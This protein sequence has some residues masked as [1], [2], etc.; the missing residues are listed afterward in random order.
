LV[1]EY[2]CFFGAWILVLG[3]SGALVATPDA[4]RNHA[5]LFARQFHFQFVKRAG[6]R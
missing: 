1:F 5:G 4:P 6:V 3:A 2:W